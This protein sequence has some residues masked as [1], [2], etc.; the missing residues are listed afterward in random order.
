MTLTRTMRA[1]GA[2]M[3]SGTLLF[4]VTPT[5]SADA[6]RDAQWMNRDFDVNDLW[7]VSKGNGVIVAVIDSGVDASHPDLAGSV[8]PGYDPSGT[9]L[10]THPTDGHGTGMASL[11]AGHGHGT[12]NTDGLMGL[13]PGAKILPIYKADSNNTDVVPQDIHWAVDHGAK[14][15]N[16]SL[17]SAGSNPQ[18]PEAVA[19]A[20]KH[21]VLIVAGS[22][23]D[24]SSTIGSPG[25]EPGVLTVGAV[26]E[27]LN[28]WPK[29]DYGPQLLLTAPGDKVVAAGLT[30]ECQGSLYC[31]TNGTSDATAYVSAAAA[32]IRAKFPELTAGQ[33]ANRLTETAKIPQSAQG[34]SLPDPHYGY[35]IIAPYSALT[36]DI[37]AGP[38]QGPLAT[39]TALAGASASPGQPAS[40][41]STAV[42]DSG[43]GFSTLLAVLGGGLVL[44][45][46]IV[47]LV[48]VVSRKRQT[49]LP[50]PMQ[51]GIP[52]H[53]GVPGYPPAQPPYGQQPYQNP[54]QQGGGPQR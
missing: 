3:L 34:I 52:P 9:G 21:D 16:I 19:Y 4:A 26:G 23:N 14:V 54:Y 11:I 25:N 40:G 36:K 33:V 30:S 31:M 6:V 10:N 43:A 22:G 29:S 1:L 44:I 37:P 45:I 8:L 53:P 51:P 27:D 17:T 32:L 46:L 18:L 5:A 2:T 12:G 47:V 20:A 35:G 38:A 41:S 42:K 24:G 13:A 15:I 50:A 28:V 49:S 48:V 39:P 7:S